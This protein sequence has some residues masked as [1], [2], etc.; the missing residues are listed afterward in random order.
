MKKISTLG[1]GVLFSLAS[2]AQNGRDHFRNDDHANVKVTIDANRF[3]RHPAVDVR[4]NEQTQH[5]VYNNKGWNNDKRDEHSYG[6]NDYNRRNNAYDNH[7]GYDNDHIYIS[8]NS[9]NYNRL[10]SNQDFFAAERVMDRENDNGR[11]LYAE[12][13][14]DDNCLTAEQVEDLARYFSFDAC[15]FD[16]VKYAFNKITDKGNFSI[17][18]NAFLSEN[19]RDQVVNFIRSCR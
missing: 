17:V 3:D 4:E 2:F 13:L 6:N 19:G 12:R 7:H 10:L 5:A 14:V 11:L 8:N 9:Y 15:R 18:C 16:F 1:F